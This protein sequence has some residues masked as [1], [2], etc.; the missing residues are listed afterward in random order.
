MPDIFGH[1]TEKNYS[2]GYCIR[3]GGTFDKE[4]CGNGQSYNAAEIFRATEALLNYMEAEYMLT[5]SLNS[6]HIVEYWQTVRKAAG[7][8]GDAVNPQV[9]IDATDMSQEKLDWGAW[10]SGQLLTDKVL[11]NIRRERRSE[12]LGEGLRAMDCNA[13]APTTSSSPH[14]S[15]TRACTS[16]TLQ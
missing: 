4:F 7:F 16:G 14:H 9:T 1:N 8:T 11:Y 15:S 5:K 13:G 2:T 6:G 3:K 10:T 12:L